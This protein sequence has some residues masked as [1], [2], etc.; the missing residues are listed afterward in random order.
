MIFIGLGAVIVVA[1]V[2]IGLVAVL[3][4]GGNASAA[5]TDAGCT[6]QTYPSQGA[7]HVF[8]PE[9][10]FSYNSFP[11]T[12][13]QHNPQPAIW[14]F[15]DRPVPFNAS[16]HNLEHSG[17]I[18]QY[19]KDVPQSTIDEIRAWYDADPAGILVS[20]LTGNALAD[21][22]ALTAW[23]Q[24]AVCPGFNEA[25]FDSFRDQYRFKGP[26]RLPAEVMQPGM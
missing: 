10:G 20:P 4:G 9:E 18:V 1:A 2:A 22:V 16:T 8:E 24:L 15:Y 23:T 13:G 25:A 7:K 17:I 3:G 14:N 5:L 21:K 11:P 26:E 12:S 19:G 6:H